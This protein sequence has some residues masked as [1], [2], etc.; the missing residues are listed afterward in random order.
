[1]N[2]PFAE[3]YQKRCLIVV[4]LPLSAPENVSSVRTHFLNHFRFY[5]EFK[6]NSE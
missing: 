6:Q 1:M 3:Q 5:V 2:F 4:M